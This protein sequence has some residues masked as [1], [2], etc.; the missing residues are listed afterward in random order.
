MAARSRANHK[1]PSQRAERP[2]PLRNRIDNDPA[3]TSLYHG[4][5][6]PAV[7]TKG[8]GTAALGPS[9][10]S[11]SGSDI[12]GGPGLNR[13][14]GL[15]PPPGTTSDPDIDAIGATAGPDIGDANLDSDTDR[16]GTGERAAA[17]RDSTVATDLILRDENDEV[18]DAES[19]GD[20]T[21]AD[22][23]TAAELVGA[24]VEQEGLTDDRI[25]A[26]PPGARS[27]RPAQVGQDTI[28]TEDGQ[29]DR[30]GQ[31]SEPGEKD[32]ARANG[33]P[34]RDDVPVFDRG[35]REDLPHDRRRRRR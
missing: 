13:D 25:G 3:A 8:H 30:D 10:S 5:E 9:D 20:S 14:D 19:L 18:V 12:Q 7:V 11:D 4:D 27:Y 6:A 23:P 24:S 34:S 32:H 33:K 35:G 28:A 17:G 1:S 21:D 26:D 31:A 29:P 16:G 22:A 15:M 2:S